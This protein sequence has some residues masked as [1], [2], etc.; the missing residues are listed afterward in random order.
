MLPSVAGGGHS[1]FHEVINM[2]PVQIRSEPYGTEEIRYPVSV[3]YNLRLPFRLT[4]YD[5]NCRKIVLKKRDLFLRVKRNAVFPNQSLL[6]W[7]L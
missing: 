3:C 7:T 5:L 4:Q 1:N 2:A 6:F